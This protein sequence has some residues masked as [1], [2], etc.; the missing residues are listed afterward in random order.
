MKNEILSILPKDFPWQNTLFCYDS[1]T[2]TNDLAK[3]MAREGAPE[4]TTVVARCQTAGRGR[5]GRQFHAP[6]GLG[7]YFSLILRPDCLPEDIFHLTCAAGV[8]ACNAVEKAAGRRPQIKWTNDLVYNHQKLG[9]ILTELSV[10]TSGKV[11]W[12]VVGI[13]INCLQEKA[14]DFPPDIR[15]FATSMLLA[16]GQA[17][18]PARLAGHLIQ[19]LYPICHFLIPKKDA[20]MQ[21]YR[22]DCMTIGQHVVLLRGDEKR[23]GTA[24]SIDDRGGL[25]V[26]F[27]DGT[28][29]SVQAGEISVRGMYG[30]V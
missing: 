16:T 3:A 20:I 8:A 21:Q 19:A 25:I 2:S 30:Y 26:K 1:V 5:L 18:S 29:E 7:L 24:L 22:Q 4:G 27:Q 23:Y 6:D 15:S 12:A 10:T 9:G 14:E 13:G 17:C 11:E 28:T